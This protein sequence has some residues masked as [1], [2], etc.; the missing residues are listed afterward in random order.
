MDDVNFRFESYRPIVN[1]SFFL[2]LLLSC[3]CVFL[4]WDFFFFGLPPVNEGL[5][6]NCPSFMGGLG[7][8][9]QQQ[10]Q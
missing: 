10:L 9:I 8:I 3:C 6:P 4:H 7:L 5:F 2:Q 1:F